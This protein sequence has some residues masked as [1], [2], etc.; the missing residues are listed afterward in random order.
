MQTKRK[1]IKTK[2]C[3][4]LLVRR[5]YS[6]MTHSALHCSHCCECWYS[7][8]WICHCVVVW[9]RVG[10]H[11]IH[12]RKK[13]LINDIWFR[14]RSLCVTFSGCALGRCNLIDFRKYSQME[15]IRFVHC[16]SFTNLSLNST[17][18]F[19]S[20]HVLCSHTF[21]IGHM[22]ANGIARPSETTNLTNISTVIA[23]RRRRSRSRDTLFS[24][25]YYLTFCKIFFIQVRSSKIVSK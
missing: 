18:N 13:Q 4:V 21:R 16:I 24:W 5:Y 8:Y 3:F 19:D 7:L 17:F 2:T 6:M 11:Q 25:S 10:V 20:Q 15:S 23:A 1:W 9:K 12:W 14:V 22:H